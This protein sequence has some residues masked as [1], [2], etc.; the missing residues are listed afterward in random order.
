MKTTKSAFSLIEVLTTVFITATIFAFLSIVVNAGLR[1]YRQTKDIIN[2]TKNAQFA[3]Q[4]ITSEI[5]EIMVDPG[6]SYSLN[7][8][9]FIA[10]VINS[11]NIDLCQI[12]YQLSSTNLQRSI[13]LP[14]SLSWFTRTICENVTGFEL[15]YYDGSSWAS[16]WTSTTVLPQLIEVQ[17]T[18]QGEYTSASGS[19]ALEYTFVTQVYLP[20]SKTG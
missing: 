2:I 4:R 9:D 10:P 17:L 7:S 5:S 20:N 15:R 19:P 8:I 3:L 16:S 18:I 12:R 1:T 14:G 13:I 11:H 6:S